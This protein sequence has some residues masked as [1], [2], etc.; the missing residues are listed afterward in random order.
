VTLA[1]ALRFAWLYLA[2]LCA[3]SCGGGGNS[4]GGSGGSTTPTNNVVSVTVSGGPENDSLNTLYT[5]VTVC[6]PGTSNCQTIDNIQV[7]TGS[8]GLR[9]LAPALML[10]LP[11]AAAST[12][13]ALV[14]CTEFIDGYSWGPVALV[15]VQIAGESASS[16]PVQLIGDARYPSVPTDCSSGAPESENT[17]ATFGANGI[18][19]IGPFAQDCGSF[20]AADI[21]EPIMYYSCSTASACVGTTVAVASQ[22]QNPVPLFA[23]D[24]NGTIIT[25]PMVATDGAANVGGSLIFGI[26]TQS[27][28]QSGSQTVVPVATSGTY[29]GLLTTIFNGQT[30]PA[31]FIDSGSNAIYFD[32]S[33]ITQCSSSGFAGFYCPSSTVTLTAA[34]QL[35]GATATESFSISN[36]EML[37]AAFMAFPDLGGTNPTPQSF[38]WG[39]PFFYGRRVATAIQ[40]YATS[41]GTGPYVAF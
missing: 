7:D 13:S 34:L 5:T 31:S 23:T 28:N 16:V 14:E 4:L 33:N 9:L 19:G 25:L 15:D 11:V 39:L 18:L 40:G 36:A 29:V 37:S 12:G 26:D 20:C 24:N 10:S 32:D 21:P 30:L 6:I 17:V 1:R 22:V 27:N 38:D 2:C 3:V 41:A 35:S 8:F